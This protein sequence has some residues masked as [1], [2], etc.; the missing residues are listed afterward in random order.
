[1][2]EYNIFRKRFSVAGKGFRFFY[3]YYLFR[4]FYDI[5]DLYY[6]CGVARCANN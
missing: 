5:K 4:L 6:G 2:N 1:M 3:F